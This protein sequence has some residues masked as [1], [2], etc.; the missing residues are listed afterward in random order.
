[1]RSLLFGEERNFTKQGLFAVWTKVD[2]A[3]AIS[4]SHAFV[5]GFPPTPKRR[6]LYAE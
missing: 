6:R 1:M 3:I 2:Q 5:N 4:R